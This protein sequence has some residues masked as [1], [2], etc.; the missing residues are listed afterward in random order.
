MKRPLWFLLVALLLVSLV[1][2]SCGSSSDMI[3]IVTDATGPP[4]E[5]V[6]EST[7]AIVGF[8]IDLITAIAEKE[9]LEVEII[10]VP[11]DSLLSGMA[12]CEYDAAISM[13]TVTAERAEQIAFSDPYFAAGQVV[14]VRSEN[15]TI[16]GRDDLAGHTVGVQHGTTSDSEAQKIEGAIIQDYADPASA[17]DAL[18]DGQVDAVIIDNPMALSYVGQNAGQLKIVGDAFTDEYY[19][20][21]VCKTNTALLD[22]INRGLAAVKAEG[23]IEELTQQW[24][25]GG[26]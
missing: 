19:G 25:I 3:T 15:T 4:F 16:D 18:L 26:Q 7:Q 20:I 22:R 1:L 13:I 12:N 23:L 21:A 24:V 10:S 17:F 2:P 6:D 11:W 8:D 14:V 9:G 5:Y